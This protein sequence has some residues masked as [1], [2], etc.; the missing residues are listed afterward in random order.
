MCEIRG[1]TNYYGRCL[2]MFRFVHWSILLNKVSVSI[3]KLK[4]LNNV[5]HMRMNSVTSQNDANSVTLH[6][7]L[8]IFPP[9]V[10]SEFWGGNLW[11]FRELS[12]A[13]DGTLNEEQVETVMVPMKKVNKLNEAFKELKAGVAWLEQ[14]SITVFHCA[15]AAGNDGG[16]GTAQPLGLALSLK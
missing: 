10:F 16:M 11:V 5:P 8:L 12:I 13:L 9:R 14:P 2:L 7:K 3:S 6:F 4:L 1:Q 15:L